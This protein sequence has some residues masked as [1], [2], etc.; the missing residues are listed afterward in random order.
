VKRRTSARTRPGMAAAKKA[1][2]AAGEVA[3]HHADRDPEVV[4]GEGGRAALRGEE[5]GDER[6]GGRAAGGLADPHADPREGELHEV[7]GEAA[8]AR[9]HAPDR[10]TDRDDRAAHAAVGPT[11][12]R[13]P[14]R[15]VEDREGEP[16]QEPHLGIRRAERGL[17]RLDQDRQNLPVDEV[18]HVDE[19]EDPEHVV[20]V[21]GIELAGR[22][23]T[24]GTWRRAGGTGVF[25]HP[26]DGITTPNRAR[27]QVQVRAGENRYPSEVPH[28]SGPPPARPLGDPA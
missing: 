10:E 9:H 28:P 7:L 27:P 3:D 11:R 20:R 13:D 5:V 25:G 12:Q 21:A 4:D 1:D 17:D 14:E 26:G 6:V 2:P 23:R 18:H 22:G 8:E 15:R 16:G 24:G 19:K